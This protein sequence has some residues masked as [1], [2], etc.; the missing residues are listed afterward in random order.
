MV[1]AHAH[2]GSGLELVG[3]AAE[4]VAEHLGPVPR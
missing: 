4:A 2:P 1:G 3:L